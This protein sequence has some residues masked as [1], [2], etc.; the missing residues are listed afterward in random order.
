MP[1]FLLPEDAKALALARRGDVHVFASLAPRRT[2]L[3]VIDMQN[4][5][6]ARG[7]MGEVAAARDIVG[8]INRLAE[9]V[10]AAGGSVFW[11]QTSAAKALQDWPVLHETLLD[12]ARRDRRLAELN[13]GHAGFALFP[14]LDQRVGDEYVTKTHYSAFI[15]GSSDIEGRLRGRGI[16]TLLVAGTATNVCCESSARDAMMR[17]FKVA[18]ISDA[19]AAQNDPLHATALLGFYSN[20]GDVLTVDEALAGLA[21]RRATGET[22]PPAR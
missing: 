8:A 21:A 1:P 12:P 10:H 9:G 6:V 11:V 19:C 18:M 22:A 2:A 3:L 5:F 15:Q 7:F 16:D 4:Y 13:E 20:F 14:S 17:N